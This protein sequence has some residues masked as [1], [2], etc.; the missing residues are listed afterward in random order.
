MARL[1]VITLL[2][3]F[4]GA[5]RAD[6]P[7]PVVADKVNRKVVKIFGAG[8]FRSVT[9]Y[10]T[11]ILIS[12]DGHILTVASQLLDTSEIVVHLYDGRRMVAQTL[13][14]EPELD[15]ALLKIKVEGK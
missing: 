8:G 12:A 13:V 3:S 7:F 11:G 14:V 15:C 6:D 9:S 10:G 4:T 2:V 1:L 5:A